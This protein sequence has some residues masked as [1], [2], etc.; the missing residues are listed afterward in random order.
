MSGTQPLPRRPS[1]PIP[2][3]LIGFPFK[4]IK[5]KIIVHKN[6]LSSSS[7]APH[8]WPNPPLEDTDEAQRLFS[9]NLGVDDPHRPSTNAHDV[10]VQIR[11]QLLQ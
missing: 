9:I 11:C 6:T 7:S 5:T 1:T 2:F 10:T 3:K 4:R 8:T